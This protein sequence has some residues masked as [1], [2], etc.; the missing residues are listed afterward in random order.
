MFGF[1]ETVII[2]FLVGATVFALILAYCSIVDGNPA[3]T[4]DKS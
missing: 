2:G 1:G 3:S 4:S